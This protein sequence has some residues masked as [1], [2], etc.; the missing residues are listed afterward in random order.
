M[1][2]RF[3][4]GDWA[5]AGGNIQSIV[6]Y[7]AMLEVLYDAKLLPSQDLA[8]D[9][10]IGCDWHDYGCAEGDGLAYLFAML[11]GC[12]FKGFDFSPNAV[13]N[14]SARWPTL[15]FA[16][17]NVWRPEEEADIISCLH[18]LEHL[19]SPVT[20][21]K[22]LTEKARIAVIAIT[23]VITAAQDGGHVGAQLT[24]EY[25]AEVK[26]LEPDFHHVYNTYRRVEDIEDGVPTIMNEGNNLWII[27]GTA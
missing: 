16:V 21:L 8:N 3:Q 19:A 7:A 18:T 12:N 1:D 2:W 6:F 9:R 23:P 25:D 10:A 20:A 14:A 13:A 4:E 15:D 17:G 27:K 11:P 26:A 24:A 5:S 22:R